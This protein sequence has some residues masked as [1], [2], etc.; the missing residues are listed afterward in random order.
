MDLK[1]S[2]GS[3]IVDG[4][5]GKEYLDMFSMYASGSVGYNHP[6]IL[7]IQDSLGSAAIH[8]PTLSDIYNTSYADFVKTFNSI[9]VPDYLK[10]TFFIEG[11]ALAVENALKAAFDWK[12]R[13]NLES[14]LN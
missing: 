7:N 12:Y 3:W 9:A 4:R 5:D 2:H 11:G 1:N 14:I 6:R 10:H 13:K 8:K